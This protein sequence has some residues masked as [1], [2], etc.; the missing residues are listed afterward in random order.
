M[1]AS[2]RADKVLTRRDVRKGRPIADMTSGFTDGAEEV[3]VWCE[4]YKDWTR[5]GDVQEL[6]CLLV[7]PVPQ[8]TRRLRRRE[9]AGNRWRLQNSTSENLANK[10]WCKI[11]PVPGAKIKIARRSA[12][13]FQMRRRDMR[14]LRLSCSSKG[15]N[16]DRY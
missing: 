14:F 16:Y 3:L 1:S 7:G 6:R 13:E 15:N 11:A 8:E 4:G 2:S 10:V 9:T 12:H 5:A